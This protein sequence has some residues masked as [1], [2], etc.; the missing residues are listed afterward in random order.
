MDYEIN[1]R[2]IITPTPFGIIIE[3]P[4]GFSTLIPN[5]TTA[6]VMRMDYH[7]QCA[8]IY[9]ANEYGYNNISRAYCQYRITRGLRKGEACGAPCVIPKEGEPPSMYC[10]AHYPHP[11]GK[12]WRTQPH[13][14]PGGQ[15]I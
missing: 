4:T 5:A 12:G 11:L 9:K 13:S 15:G 7:Q 2:C 14:A 3:T 6:A 1:T 8:L 10:L